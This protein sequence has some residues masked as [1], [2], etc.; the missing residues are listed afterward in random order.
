MKKRI[1]FLILALVMTVACSCAAPSEPGE[2]PIKTPGKTKATD[3][4][5]PEA[6]PFMY[7][8]AKSYELIPDPTF[9]RGMALLSQKDHAH[10]DRVEVLAKHSFYGNE[11]R[12]TRWSLCQWDS[13]P[14]LVENLIESDPS[15]ITDGKSRMFKY[16]PST[17]TMT[18]WLDTSAYY[19]GKPAVL[20]DYWPHLLIETS[21]YSYSS[22]D[23]DEQ[24]FFRCDS[25]AIIISFDIK[26]DKYSITPIEG[27][28]VEAAQF[29]LYVYVKGIKTNDFCWF[30]LQLF[31]NRYDLSDNYIGYDGG[32]ADA[33][34]A[35][36]FSIGSK[37]VYENSHRTLYKNGVP[38]AGGDWVHV[39]I[40]IKPFLEQMFEHG[41]SE[42][43]FKAKSLSELIIN[44]MNLGWETI[45]TFDHQMEMRNLSVKSYR[46]E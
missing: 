19:R 2:T 15:T 18:F 42:K 31:D 24:L 28:W 27:D 5:E 13:G 45:A 40:D 36:I 33:S 38:D 39:S 7:E 41:K 21:D 30:G 29:L 11:P 4:P 9:Q 32:K 20:G 12:A 23:P 35:M 14:C 16:E 1:L 34:G 8:N 25:D 37:Y 3:T 44:G 6:T 22:K 10:G 26:L 43:Y 46:T 17:N